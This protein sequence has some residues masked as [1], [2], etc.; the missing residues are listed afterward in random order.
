[1]AFSPDGH[2]L[3]LGGDASAR[4]VDTFSGSELSSY[5]HDGWVRAVAFSPDGQRLATAGDD[6][7]V[8]VWRLRRPS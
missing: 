8:R 2:S 3:A 6:G 7:T 4:V 5:A 1:V